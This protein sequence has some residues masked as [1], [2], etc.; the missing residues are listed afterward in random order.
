MLKDRTLA[1][2]AASILNAGCPLS[3]REVLPHRDTLI[4]EGLWVSS[5]ECCIHS[6][7]R[8]SSEIMDEFRSAIAWEVRCRAYLQELSEA[9]WAAGVRPVVF[10]GACL[11]LVCY[12]RPGQRAFGDIDI[13]ISTP[14]RSGFLGVLR[15]LGYTISP[16][17]D[18]AVRQGLS[19]DLHHH[20][21]HQM[22]DFFPS[23]K[24]WESSVLPLRD[25]LVGL[26][27]LSPHHEFVLAL[28][29]SGKH[30]F[31]RASHVVD[32]LVM[33]QRFAPQALVNAVEEYRLGRHLWLASCLA[34]T[35][36]DLQFPPGMLRLCRSP[37]R[38]DVLDR[39]FAEQ[40]TI[41]RAPD[42]LGMLTPLW[43]ITGWRRR[44][45]YLLQTLFPPGRGLGGRLSHLK[46]LT[47]KVSQMARRPRLSSVRGQEFPEAIDLS[48]SE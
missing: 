38:F 6:G 29:H 30:A 47:Q 17:G 18:C 40:V 2:V 45:R 7:Q 42:F 43:A 9:C 12:P 33:A 5:L 21:L 27:R 41:R 48:T 11:A 19:V 20:P 28:L 35:W 3:A 22:S 46:I 34:K 37:G 14:Q 15:S 23:S 36:F 24:H 13:A 26:G 39:W 1:S 10:K 4:A 16:A 25:D 8:F 32:L 44:L 31:S